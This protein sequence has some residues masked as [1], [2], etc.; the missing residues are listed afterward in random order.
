MEPLRR[1]TPEAVDRQGHRVSAAS[2]RRLKEMVA[3]VVVPESVTFGD[4]QILASS[5][6]IATLLTPYRES[7]VRRI[8]NCS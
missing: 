6:Q 7:E 4:S 2:L 1:D 3:T 8:E 5:E